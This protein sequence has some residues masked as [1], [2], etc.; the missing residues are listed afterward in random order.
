MTV[1]LSFSRSQSGERYSFRKKVFDDVKHL[2]IV[3]KYDRCSCS[4]SSSRSFVYRFSKYAVSVVVSAPLNQ[5]LSSFN[6]QFQLKNWNILENFCVAKIE[7]S[8]VNKGKILCGVLKFNVFR[9]ASQWGSSKKLEN[10]KVFVIIGA[11]VKAFCFAWQIPPPRRI[12]DQHRSWQPSHPPWS[13]TTSPEWR[14]SKIN[15]GC[16]MMDI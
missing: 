14:G 4:G 3:S 13:Q 16:N 5:F 11:Y 15:A 8:Q 2:R 10:P 1:V 7:G 6:F 12:P 9:L